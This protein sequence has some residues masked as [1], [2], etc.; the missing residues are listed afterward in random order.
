[1]TKPVIIY[2]VILQ[3]PVKKY[4]V[5]SLKY[6]AA[7]AVNFAV[8]SGIKTVVMPEVTVISFGV[9]FVIV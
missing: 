7:V 6:L 3:Q 9:M 8:L 4:F 5:D 1:M 2:K